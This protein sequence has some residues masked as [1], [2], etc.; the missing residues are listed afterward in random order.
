MDWADLDCPD[1]E[2]VPELLAA[3]AEGEDDVVE[4]AA[5]DLEDLLFEGDYRRP[6]VAVHL[7]P[8]LTALYPLLR[9][10][11]RALVIRMFRVVAVRGDLDAWPE[12]RAGLAEVE[13]LLLADLDG[14]GFGVRREVVRFLPLLTGGDA[15][16]RAAVLLDLIDCGG[17]LGAE[18]LTA[19][20]RV[21]PGRL[22]DDLLGPEHTDEVRFAAA[23]ALARSGRPWTSEAT[24]VIVWCWSRRA[25]ETASAPVPDTG[26][27]GRDSRPELE[28]AVADPTCV[29]ELLARLRVEGW[30][31]LHAARTMCEW[32]RSA[33]QTLVPVF[34]AALADPQLRGDALS[35]LC[36]MPRVA[37]SAREPAAA[38]AT[39]A[40]LDSELPGDR[41][42]G[43]EAVRLLVRL[44]DP[45]GREAL[46]GQLRRRQ[47]SL[48]PPVYKLHSEEVPPDPELV[49][50][51]NDALPE[52]Y[53]RVAATESNSTIEEMPVE[54]L[55]GWGPEAT[56][57]A[58]EALVG[59][60]EH[61]S[62]PMD[63][64]V[65]LGPR[66]MAALPVLYRRA[67]DLGLEPRDRLRAAVAVVAVGAD[68]GPLDGLLARAKPWDRSFGVDYARRRGVVARAVVAD[69]R[70]QAEQ[71]VA[72]NW[73]VSSQAVD[74]AEYLFRAVGETATPLTVCA[75]AL[76]RFGWTDRA[77][78]SLVRRLGREV[79]RSAEVMELFAEPAPELWAERERALALVRVTG[80]SGPL[81]AVAAHMM[82]GG[83]S[84]GDW[85]RGLGGLPEV[86]AALGKEADPLRPRLRELCVLE[87]P[88]VSPRLEGRVRADELLRAAL[89]AVLEDGG[90]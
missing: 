37:T 3:L 4:E 24:R 22:T 68:E 66:A 48:Y 29:D 85:D 7:L 67:S 42:D 80:E 6:A 72:R 10:A 9:G 5:E 75:W 33:R 26:G 69:Q 71:F 38:L 27:F 82:C 55:A 54:L 13:P 64:V 89:G 88:L 28:R 62:A 31:A 81:H 32:V 59:A 79:A 1:A 84:L 43:G 17:V 51:L 45:R 20:A 90:A 25:W 44:G 87:A 11:R 47:C 12:L 70:E 40:V 23:R 49:E 36:E 41:V 46:L 53:A 83:A 15:D 14:Q 58:L 63:A 65:A 77:V 39:P 19:L 61:S 50:A 86:I 2:D 74:A 34:T 76:R 56:E 78:C 35:A 8:R 30:A 73:H 21:D 18:A 57:R 16:R 52:Y 60:L